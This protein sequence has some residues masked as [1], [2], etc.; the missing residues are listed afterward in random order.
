MRIDWT[1]LA[2]QLINFAILVWLLQRFLYRPVLKVIDARRQAGDARYAEAQRMAETAKRQLADVAA[3]RVGVAADRAAALTDAREQARQLVASRRAEAER[4]AKVLLDETRQTLAR[5]RESLLAEARHTA[6]DL[7]ADMARR[8]LAEIP[9]PLRIETWLERID[10]RLR[11]L[12]ASERAELVGELAG[13]EALRVVSAWPISSAVQERWHARLQE[14]LGQ[15]VAMTFETSAGLIAGAELCFPHSTL[16]FCVEG[17]VRALQEEA[18]R[19]GE[20]Q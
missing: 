13:G 3:Q 7:A 16:S 9:E 17:A 4:D 5:E 15:N 19:H 2:L 11:A 10:Q 18:A 12:A 1:T 20:P 6:L 8:V 14:T